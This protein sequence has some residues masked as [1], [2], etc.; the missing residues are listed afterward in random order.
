MR[1]GTALPIHYICFTLNNIRITKQQEMKKILLSSASIVVA[2]AALAQ[3]PIKLTKEQNEYKVSVP[4]QLIEQQVEKSTSTQTPL[5]TNAIQRSATEVQIGESYYDLQTNSS[6][7]RRILNHANSTIS[8]TWTFSTD[9]AWSNRGTGYNYFNGSSWGSAP[10]AE[11]ESERTGWPN[12]LR[13][14]SGKEIIISHSTASSI[15]HR[16]QRNTVGSGTWTQ[17]NLSSQSGQVWGRSATGGTNNNTIHMV[18]MTLPVANAGSLYTDGMDGAFLY[19]RSTNAGTS[20]DIVDYQIPGT[21]IA[22]FDGFDGDSY[23]IDAQGND[24]A[25]VVGG[26]GRGVQLFKSTNNGVS[27]TKTDVLTSDVW[28][29]EDATL[30]DTTLEDRLFTSDGAVTVLLDED[31][32][33]HVWFGTMFIANAD[34]TD[35]T[36]TYYP[37]TNGMEYWNEDFPGDNSLRLFGMLDLNANGQLDL[38]NSGGQYRFSGLVSH[39]QAGIDDDGCFYLSYTSVREDLVGSSQNYRHTYVTKS[40]DNGCSWSFPIDVTGGSVNDFYECVH[41]SIARRVDDEIHIVYMQDVEPGMAVSGDEDQS[42]V[43]KIIYLKEDADRFDTAAFCPTEIA[44]D[45]LLCSGGSVELQALGCGT[46]AWSGPNS[47]TSSNQVIN[48]VATGTYTCDITTTCGVQTETFDVIAYNGTGGPTVTI[49]STTLELCATETATLTASSNIGGVSYAWSNGGTSAS[50]TVI[51]SGTYTVTVQDCN[52]GSTVESVTILAPAAPEAIVSGDLTLCP[53]DNNV[54]TALPWAGATYLWSNG[55][56]SAA[57]TITAAGTYSVTVTN[58]AGNS[59][60]S[61]TITMEAMPVAVINSDATTGCVGEILTVT[62]DGGSGYVWSNGSDDPSL[63]IT[64][65]SESGTYTVTVTN[66]CGDEDT[67]E[68]T[69]TIVPNPAAPIISLV[70]GSYTSSQTGTGTHM[71]YIE[72]TLVTGQIGSTLPSS[73]VAEGNSV[74]CVYVDENGCESD[75]SNA[76]VGL[77]EVSRMNAEVSIYPNPNNGQFEVRFGDVNGLMNVTLTN[78]LGQVVYTTQVVAQ[79]GTVSNFEI[80]NLESGAYQLSLIGE[81]GQSIQQIII[82]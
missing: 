47:F 3:Q 37:Y 62:A 34:I 79:K 35:G 43:N 11:L 20:F 14:G 57:T 80:D 45:S 54:L 5:N 41:P 60:A 40:C 21:G 64:D 75:P 17:G 36:I 72:N 25:I 12:P 67:E 18:G 53:G 6:I 65:V 42:A 39:P 77:D 32:M 76:I 70:A 49:S 44:G 30:V 52:S 61:V 58:C 15:F 23:S 13:T 69:L 10:T 78:T 2:V 26:L 63:S 68:I 1:L 73:A 66:D 19:T 7:Q 71:W 56:A 59:I 9:A 74:Y 82:E 50:T 38:D 16:V 81:A 27:W 8:A 4:V 22:Y 51:G 33:A 28:F 29:Q 24:V 46:Y 55:Q 31:G 48:A